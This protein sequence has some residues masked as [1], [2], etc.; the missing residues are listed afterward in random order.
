LN[1]FLLLEMIFSAIIS[2]K[3]FLFTSIRCLLKSSW[4][5]AN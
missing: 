4:F 1:L 2:I 3:Y 5:I